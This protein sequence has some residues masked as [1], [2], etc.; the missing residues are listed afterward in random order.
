MSSSKSYV[1]YKAF[2]PSSH[3]VY[4][5][6]CAG[7]GTTNIRKK[8]SKNAN[9][10]AGNRQTKTFV[11]S[12]GGLDN[13]FFEVISVCSDASSAAITRNTLRDDV[14]SISRATGRKLSLD[15]DNT[16][17][18]NVDA[19]FNIR[20]VVIEKFNKFKSFIRGLVR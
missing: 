20:E 13:V 4:F 16:F 11:D 2:S 9:N 12:C 5:G 18:V 17:E 15:D 19:E 8:F 7:D 14:K 3:S 6:F 1:V 10:S